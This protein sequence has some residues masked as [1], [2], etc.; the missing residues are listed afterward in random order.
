MS[1]SAKGPV[2][3]YAKDLKIKDKKILIFDTR[4]NPEEEAKL[5]SETM[6]R[7]NKK[8]TGIEIC[9]LNSSAKEDDWKEKIKD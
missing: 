8:F 4:L 1:L 6:K 9:S 5:I 3:V 7:I 2:T